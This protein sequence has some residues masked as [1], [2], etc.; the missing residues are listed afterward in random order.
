MVKTVLL[1]ARR[2]EKDWDF[3][4]VF[5][6]SFFLSPSLLGLGGLNEG[7]KEVLYAK[8]ILKES[9]FLCVI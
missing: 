6:H 4:V 5:C 7:K 8:R 2:I 3:F 1:M 9:F